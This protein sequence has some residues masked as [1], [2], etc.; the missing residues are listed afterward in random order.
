MYVNLQLRSCQRERSGEKRAK[1]G[2]RPR[3]R[4]TAAPILP[5]IWVQ[6]RRDWKLAPL[7]ERL[8]TRTV[9]TRRDF[10]FEVFP[11]EDKPI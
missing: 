1:A 10:A 6:D 11:F 3:Q 2:A 8:S 9:L 4:L 7:E 5:K